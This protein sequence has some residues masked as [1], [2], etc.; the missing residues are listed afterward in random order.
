MLHSSLPTNDKVELADR[1][2]N[3]RKRKYDKDGATPPRDI[4]WGCTFNGYIDR[5]CEREAQTK[6]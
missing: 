1:N 4:V 5:I 2:S 3:D 6:C